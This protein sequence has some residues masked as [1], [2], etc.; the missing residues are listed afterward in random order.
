MNYSIKVVTF[1]VKPEVRNG[2]ESEIVFTVPSL[3]GNRSIPFG[4]RV[5][6]QAAFET[7]GNFQS[8]SK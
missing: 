2:L 6:E 3:Q 1:N 8:K 5:G 7:C 4:K